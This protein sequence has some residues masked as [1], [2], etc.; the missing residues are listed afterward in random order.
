[1]EK[2]ALSTNS[3][4]LME[5]IV[6]P[7]NM[8][9]AWD[10]VRSNRGAPGPDGITLAEFPEYFGP[11]WAEVRQQLLDGTYR[12][13]AARRKSIEKPDGGER[14]LGIPDVQDRVIQQAILQVLTPIFDPDFSES[15]F[16]FRPGRSAHGAIL[17]VQ[18]FIRQRYRHCVDMD[19]S[20]FFDRVQHDVLMTRVARKVHDRRLLSLIG[21][22]LR[23]GIMVDGLLQPSPEGTM[24][25]GPLSPLLANI[26]LDDLD[27]ELEKRGLHFAR[28]ADD[29]LIFTK[30]R[31]SAE[32]VF[33]SVSGY[34][35]RK[36]KLVVNTEKSRICP[37]DGV[38][39]LGFR[40]QG[41]SGQIRVST[42]NVQK[43]KEKARSITSRHRGIAM[44]QRFQE[45][46]S[47]A[48]G[49]VG[50]FGLVPIKSFFKDL[51]QWI[52]RRI[53]AC[54]WDQWRL[55]RTKFR[56][57][58]ALGLSHEKARTHANSRKGP[59][60][61]AKTLGIDV[62]MTVARLTDQGLVSLLDVWKTLAPRMRTA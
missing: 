11:L 5:Q 8:Q 13:H 60:R 4:S 19:L 10:K 30:T 58:R 53:R 55:P 16:G 18:Q 43:F 33:A 26:L 54:F 36:L 2:T 51:D 40:F 15:S 1:M 37:T 25:G 57:L 39:F 28:Y 21:R 6:D 44:E 41:L 27:K 61:S 29:F 49:W 50:Y 34:L 52:R 47:Y 31:K 59:W 17:Q 62:A 14:H 12:P 42:K 56:Q 20:K 24:Q 32:R 45:L 48:R 35:T 9:R 23:A 22:Y 46:G 38:E 7:D 3:D